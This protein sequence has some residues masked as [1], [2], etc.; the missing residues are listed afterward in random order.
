MV[1]LFMSDC[2]NLLDLFAG[3][4]GLSEGFYRKGYDFAAHVEMNKYAASTL[5][6]RSLYHFLNNN[7]NENDYYA[8]LKG[9]IDKEELMGQNSDFSGRI[10]NQEINSD[11]EDAIIKQ[12]K[13]YMVNNDMNK[14]DGIIG[15]PPC[16]AYSIIGRGRNRDCMKD[17]PRNFLYLYYL[18]IL[19][20]F[21]PDFFVFE[22]VPGMTSARKGSVFEDLRKKTEKLGY[23]LFV[24]VIN[25]QDFMVLQSRRRLI[26]IGYKDFSQFFEFNFES[27]KNYF[28]VNDLLKDLPSLE[29]G[30]GKD[31]VMDYNG[32][33]TEYLKKSEIRTHKDILIQHKARNHNDRDREIY[34][35]AIKVWNEHKKRIQYD[36]LPKKLKTHRQTKIFTDRFKVVAGDLESAQTVMAHISKDGHYYIHPDLKQA[37]SLTLREAARIQSFPDNYKFEGP[38]TA[39]YWQVGNAV[40]PLMA[41]NIAQTMKKMIG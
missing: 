37:R 29:P 9:E 5:E 39:R 36:E 33:P 25:S 14:I 13:K 28:K 7:K 38:Q 27:S 26:V 1:I 8:F 20:E 21:K 34:R 35:M 10:I 32:P 3:A 18:N 40:P 30:G 16:Q 19:K 24:D 15:G 22:N 17:D 41:A 4:G 11:S 23:R 12:I 6:T 31:G 2:I